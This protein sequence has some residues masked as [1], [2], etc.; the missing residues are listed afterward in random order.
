VAAVRVAERR[1]QRDSDGCSSNVGDLHMV[2]RRRGAYHALP[3]PSL[4]LN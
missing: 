1:F 2:L 3:N 4:D